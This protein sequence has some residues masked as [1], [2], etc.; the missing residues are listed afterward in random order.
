LPGLRRAV[1]LAERAQEPS[2]TCP[3]PTCAENRTRRTDGP[4]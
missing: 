4:R 3:C 1:T 2:Q